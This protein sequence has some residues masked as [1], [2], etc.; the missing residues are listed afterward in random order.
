MNVRSPEVC[1]WVRKPTDSVGSAQRNEGVKSRGV[2]PESAGSW[3]QK[4]VL[5]VSIVEDKQGQEVK[6]V[7]LVEGRAASLS[8]VERR[9]SAKSVAE[10]LRAVWLT[11]VSGCA[12]RIEV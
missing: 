2:T 3:R 7:M 5:K 10:L 9:V 1:R 12:W 8:I 6:K 11:A 4:S